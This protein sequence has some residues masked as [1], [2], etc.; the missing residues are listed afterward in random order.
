M[1]GS[2]PRLVATDMDGTLVRGDGT[3]S[4]YTHQVLARLRA[5]GVLLVGATG[6]GPRL[7]NLTRRDLGPAD[8]LVLA[9]GGFCYDL[10]GPEPDPIFSATMPGAAIARA[11]SLVEATAGPVFLTV[12]ALPAPN[13]PLWRDPGFV[14]PYPE[15]TEERSRHDSLR[16]TV[17]KAFLRSPTLPL[18]ELLAICRKVIPSNLCE[19]SSPGGMVEL[20]PPGCTKASGLMLVTEALGID[21]GDVLV[22]GDMPNDVPMF[23]WAG[24]AVAVAGAHPEVLAVADE[25]TG[26]NDD[27][28][29]ASH[30]EQLLT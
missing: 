22:F 6:R 4:A 14:W 7:I 2:L 12:E 9:Q 10:T 23:R 11:V 13:A 20:A 24:R 26:S 18:D 28:G 5:R 30:L 21:P 16:A 8:Y 3:V 1:T 25:V 17:I 27:D 29:V 15:P 19:A